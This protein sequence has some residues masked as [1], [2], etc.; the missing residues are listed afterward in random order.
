[1]WQLLST[2]TLPTFQ[3]FAA[4][5][6]YELVVVHIDVDGP[7]M[8]REAR[9]FKTSFI[10]QQLNLGADLVFWIDADALFLRFDTDPADL[11]EAEHFQG[12]VLEHVPLRHRTNPNTGV[13]LIRNTPE[14]I[15]FLDHI[16]LI[17]LRSGETW[18]DQAAVM[19]GL[20]WNMG[21]QDYV[22]AQAGPDTPVMLRTAWLPST[23][24]TL[25]NDGRPK[26][27]YREGMPTEKNP[28]IWHL[29]GLTPDER[30]R[31]F[32]NE[33][34]QSVKPQITHK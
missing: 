13:W 10:R 30:L 17:G 24:N 21:G 16:K 9:M 26:L 12:L 3:K 25:I 7:G 15:E 18:A 2:Y 14:A 28:H 1:M 27:W 20:G 5:H 29:A 11:L 6:G 34:S 8:L 31:V 23:F 22:G 32:E 19:R 33:Y 4:I